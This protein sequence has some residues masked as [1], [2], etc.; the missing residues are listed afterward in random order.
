MFTVKAEKRDGKGKSFSRKLRKKN[1]FPGI[2]Y[3]LNSLPIPIVIEHDSVFNLQKKEDF[4]KKNLCLLV[5]DK[6]YIVKIQAIQR[7]SFKMK[8]LH[9]DFIHVK[10]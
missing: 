6:K 10:I 8:I 5:K 2:L 3:G 9:I 4:Y 7:H 1:K